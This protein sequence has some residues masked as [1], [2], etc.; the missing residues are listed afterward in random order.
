MIVVDLR[1]TFLA[2]TVQAAND[3]GRSALYTVAANNAGPG[4]LPA[5]YSTA[6]NTGADAS[7]DPAYYSV[8]VNTG[9]ADD[10]TS[11]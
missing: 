1:T 2:S 7:Y 8:A 6:V 3:P 4:D 11:V 10:G 5:C 9:S